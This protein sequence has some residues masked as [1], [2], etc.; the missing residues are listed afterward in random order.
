[1]R[2]GSVDRLLSLG[3]TLATVASLTACNP[4][5]RDVLEVPVAV[6][7]AVDGAIADALALRARAVRTHDQPEFMD[8]VDAGERPFLRYQALLFD[9]LQELP[10]QAYDYELRGVTKLPDG[11]VEADLIESMQLRGYDTEPVRTPGRF[12]FREVNGRWVLDRDHNA[13]FDLDHHIHRQ[14]WELSRIEAEQQSGVLGIFDRDSIDAAYQI[15]PAVADGIADI[16][17]RI[18]LNWS[19]HVVVYALS[20]ITMM[21]SLD[22]LPGGNPQRLEGVAFGVPAEPGTSRLA[23]MRFMLHPRL[24]DQDT[25]RRDRLIRHE[26]THVA[27]GTRDDHVPTWLAEGLAE[28]VS[29]Q[30]VP[31]AQREISREALEMAQAGITALPV[32]E[33]FNGVHSQANY[34]IAWYACEFIAGRFGPRRVWRLLSVMDKG[35]GTPEAD[36]DAV[37][38]EV[39]GM[40]GDELAAAAGR[41]IVRTFS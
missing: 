41:Q 34:G 33:D 17:A 25:D 8:G 18:P 26:L 2:N 30:A 1:M 39:L 20:S 3:L 36:Q 32:D 40:S 4:F 31:R 14:P 10:L 13:A 23:G 11:R 22:D 24:I 37:L 6:A 15:M 29:V 12:T 9:N 38:Q 35:T 7:P 27:I 16:S 5:H 28:W 19:R 21:A